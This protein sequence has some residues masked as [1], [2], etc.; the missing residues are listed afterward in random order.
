MDFLGGLVVT[1][2]VGDTKGVF[3]LKDIDNVERPEN[4]RINSGGIFVN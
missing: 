2:V 1:V 3:V 4:Q